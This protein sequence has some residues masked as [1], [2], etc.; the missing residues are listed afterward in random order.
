M[1]LERAEQDEFWCFATN[2]CLQSDAPPW[3]AFLEPS[4][5]GASR[6]TKQPLGAMAHAGAM[7]LFGGDNPVFLATDCDYEERG[8][9]GFSVSHLK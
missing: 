8:T 4:R 5:K 7:A 2:S 9:W 3:P 6:L 1:G